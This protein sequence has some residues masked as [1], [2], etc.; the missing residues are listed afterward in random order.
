MILYHGNA[1]FH[2][3]PPVHRKG[4]L[5]SN[6]LFEN[7]SYFEIESDVYV[8]SYRIIRGRLLCPKGSFG[9]SLNFL[10]FEQN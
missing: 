8:V 2:S 6:K 7:S 3:E 10:N 9:H 1:G 5:G 4:R